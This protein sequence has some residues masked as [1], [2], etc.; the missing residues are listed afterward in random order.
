MLLIILYQYIH[1]KEILN[2]H[3]NKLYYYLILSL[4]IMI[5]NIILDYLI[6]KNVFLNLIRTLFFHNIVSTKL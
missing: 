1:F 5:Y 6:S 4:N 2:K 3:K